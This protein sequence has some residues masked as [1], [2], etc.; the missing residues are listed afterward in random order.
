MPTLGEPQ[1]APTMRLLT[2]NEQARAL[3][4]F[5][6]LLTLRDEGIKLLILHNEDPIGL[7]AI[8]QRKSIS[9]LKLL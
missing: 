3:A 2:P 5:R 4:L 9:G 1:P 8:G 7:R 6:D